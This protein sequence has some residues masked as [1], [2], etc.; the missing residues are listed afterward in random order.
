MRIDMEILLNKP[1]SLRGRWPRRLP[2]G[3]APAFAFPAFRNLSHALRTVSLRVVDF[4]G[5]L[6]RDK[7]PRDMRRALCPATRRA[8]AAVSRSR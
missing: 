6:S 8:K 1:V 4:A 2:T 5:L 3:T 7:R